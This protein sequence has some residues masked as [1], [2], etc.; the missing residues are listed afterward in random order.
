MFLILKYNL[1]YYFFHLVMMYIHLNCYLLLYLQQYL[2]LIFL[3]NHM[4]FFLIVLHF[5]YKYSMNFYFLLNLKLLFLFLDLIIL[6]LNYLLRM[7]FHFLKFLQ[8]LLFFYLLLV[9]FLN[10]QLILCNFVN[11]INFVLD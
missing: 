10:L 5:S 9:N 2:D 7:M 3:C 6:L 11:V 1:Q 4:L 8:K